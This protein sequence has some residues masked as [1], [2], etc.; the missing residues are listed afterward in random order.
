MPDLVWVLG[1]VVAA[2]LGTAAL[3]LFTPLGRKFQRPWRRVTRD[4][5][6]TLHVERRPDRQQLMG[7][8]P[9]LFFYFPD[10]SV[11]TDSPTETDWW[12]WAHERGGSD[13]GFTNI[14]LTLQASQDLPVEVGIPEV[15]HDVV[16]EPAGTFC[17]PEGVGG[18]GLDARRFVIRL[19]DD[20]PITPTYEGMMGEKHSLPRFAMTKND[21]SEILV[22]AYAEQGLHRWSLTIPC[23]V[24]G[25]SVA[26]KANDDGKP[27]VTVG[28]QG[29]PL[30]MWADG[31][32][33][34]A[35]AGHY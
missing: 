9:P 31:M 25:D 27:F 8:S 35:P 1:M 5:G 10:G 13:V 3:A 7:L 32:W 4:H 18:N 24:A 12:G 29:L 17:G 30:H 34:D 19:G 22:T 26:L 33:I 21:T 15:H 16:H 23:V 11:P 6:L 14:L 2:V 28:R 20:D